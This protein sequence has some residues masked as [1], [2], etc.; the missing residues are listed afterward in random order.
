MSAARR[1][2][3]NLALRGRRQVGARGD[4]AGDDRLLAIGNERSDV[5]VG[6]GRADPQGPVARSHPLDDLR[7]TRTLDEDARGGGARLA[8]V[9]DAGIDQERQR[10]VEIGVGEHELRRLAAELERHRRDMARR[11][12]LDQRADGDRTREGNVPHARMR[13]ERRAGLL[14]EARHDVERAG[15][16]TRLP[17]EVGERERGE[18]G[19]LRGLEHAGVAHRERRADGAAGDL[20]RI[21]P[22]HDMSGH[23]V[24]LAQGVDRV[25]V[26]I[27]DRFAHHLVGRAGVELHVARHRQRVGAA[28]LHAACRRRA[29]R[30]ARA[31]RPGR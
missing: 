18:A 29:P 12:R 7:V 3:D 31:P 17:R 14:A 13:G 5:E 27:G 23:A 1:V 8:R 28:L 16:K 22:R 11:R 2:G 10:A 30:S 24:R 25:A 26:E 4:E 19:F 21:V 20:H 15:G 6:V 9:L